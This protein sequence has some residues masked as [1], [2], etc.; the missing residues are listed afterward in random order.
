M[1]VKIWV[2]LFLGQLVFALPAT[3]VSHTELL[4]SYDY[5]IAGGGTSGLTV[6]NRLTEDSDGQSHQCKA[7]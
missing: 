5:V 6:A 4:S 7:K 3:I 2:Q 1:G